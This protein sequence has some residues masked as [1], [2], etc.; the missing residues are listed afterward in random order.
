MIENRIYLR[1]IKIYLSI[2]WNTCE[3][4][5]CVIWFMSWNKKLRVS[6]MIASAP[7]NGELLSIEVLQIRKCETISNICI[8][9]RLVMQSASQSMKCLS[10]QMFRK[11]LWSE[12]FSANKSRMQH[13]GQKWKENTQLKRETMCLNV[14]LGQII[15]NVV[16]TIFSSTFSFTVLWKILKISSHKMSYRISWAK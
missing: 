13:K 5:S 10:S 1:S 15:I 6:S 2:R 8:L 9:K 7:A 11:P 4:D 3:T 12:K 16:C 14:S